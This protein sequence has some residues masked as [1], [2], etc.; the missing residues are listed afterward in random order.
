MDTAIAKRDGRTFVIGDSYNFNAHGPLS[1][2]L[3]CLMKE[4]RTV[5]L[6][7]HSS[8]CYC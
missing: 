5:G 8:V 3:D 7:R 2:L 1:Y 6:V 4:Q